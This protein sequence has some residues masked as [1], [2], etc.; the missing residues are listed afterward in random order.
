MINFNAI[1]IEKINKILII[2]KEV[3]IMNFVFNIK[4]HINNNQ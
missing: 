2:N 3:F 1:N 4:K